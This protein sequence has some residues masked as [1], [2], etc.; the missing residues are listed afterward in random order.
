[1]KIDVNCCIYNEKGKKLEVN[2]IIKKVQEMDKSEV[3][4]TSVDIINQENDGYELQCNSQI[5]AKGNI[6]F[7]FDRQELL[8]VGKSLNIKQRLCQHLIKCPK[9]TY[10][11]IQEVHQYLIKNGISK[12][13]Y[14]TIDVNPDCYYGLIEGMIIK[15]I[16][17]NKQNFP[18]NWNLRED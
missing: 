10:S 13:S 5:N 3:V 11:K 2:D 14:C 17:K 9:S 18:N 1:M 8:Y 7:I 16:H 6:Y 4:Y 12:L 15:Y